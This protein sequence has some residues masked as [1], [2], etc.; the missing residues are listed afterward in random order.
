MHTMEGISSGLAQGPSPV[1]L[2][3]GLETAE[4]LHTP[5]VS[6]YQLT[7][8]RLDEQLAPLK[9]WPTL[10]DRTG[11]FSFTLLDRCGRILYRSPT[12]RQALYREDELLNGVIASTRLAAVQ[13]GQGFPSW[14]V[15]DVAC[16]MYELPATQLPCA[17]CRLLK[18]KS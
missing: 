2:L 18:C 7:C 13:V 12:L 14:G 1:T 10:P 3:D 17:G 11:R 15:V 5:P 16:P 8:A 9:V 6:L 4:P